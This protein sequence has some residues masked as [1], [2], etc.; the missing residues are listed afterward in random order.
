MS[1][2]TVR[3]HPSRSGFDLS[4]RMIFSAKVGE[5]L[6]VYWTKVLP[7]NYYEIKHQNFTRTMPVTTPAFTR[8]REYF[9]WYYVPLRLLNKNVPPS[10]FQLSDQPV[11]ATSITESRP[12]LENFPYTTSS[13]FGHLVNIAWYNEKY[14]PGASDNFPNSILN[15]FGFKVSACMAKLWRYMRFG[16]FIDPA[17]DVTPKVSQVRYSS[18]GLTT[19][20]DAFTFV[21]SVA[22]DLSPF[23]SYQKIYQD[24]FR[25]EQWEKAEPFCYNTDYYPGT[26]DLFSQ[27][28]DTWAN[29]FEAAQK[30][31][32]GNNVFTLRYCNWMKDIFQGVMPSSQL[33]SVAAIPVQ[34]SNDFTPA[35]FPV[36]WYS[37]SGIVNPSPNPN[38]DLKAYYQKGGASGDPS[39][40]FVLQ[41]PDPVPSVDGMYTA[42]VRPYTVQSFNAE[43]SVLQL[44]LGEALQKYREVSQCAGQT[45]REQLYAHFNVKLSKALSDLSYHIGGSSANIDISEV[46]NQNLSD[47]NAQADLKGKGV[48]TGRSSERFKADEHGILMCLYHAVPLMD[49]VPTG[50]DPQLLDVAMTDYPVP[51]FDSIGMESLSAISMWNAPLS[52][53][54]SS[55]TVLSPTKFL[56]GYVPR[57]IAYKT[58]YDVVTGMFETTQTNWVSAYGPAYLSKYFTSFFS[59]PD[60]TVDVASTITYAFFKCNPHILDSIFGVECDST[61][62]TDQLQVNAYFDVSVVQNLD[63]NGMPY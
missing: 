23:L 50:V 44:R 7:G 52:I 38:G 48:G 37:G 1:F 46:V 60:T 17:N 25:F 56:L 19:K 5:I 32:R 11:Q 4:R 34:T 42:G 24:H 33:G 28:S 16:N 14:I 51:E 41:S 43:V 2:G 36:Q 3:N 22:V 6:P 20:H 31:V 9:D 61:W 29:H 53:G 12:V 54:N 58:A 10:L 62:D 30:Y 49:Y 39:K 15:M 45:Y 35:T 8:I 21:D 18:A 13:M 47:A 63:Y 59:D 26:G 55:N 57:Y 40:T 27:F